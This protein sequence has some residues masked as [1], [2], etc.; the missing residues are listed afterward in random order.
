[1]TC[2]FLAACQAELVRVEQLGVASL[3]NSARSQRHAGNPAHDDR[4]DVIPRSVARCAM[5]KLAMTPSR[6]ARRR[7][8]TGNRREREFR[9]YCY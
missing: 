5:D 1:M 8:D 3:A 7:P 9:R 2:C 4:P 6:P